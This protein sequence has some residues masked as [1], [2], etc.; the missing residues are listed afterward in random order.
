MSQILNVVGLT[1][2]T[3]VIDPGK[4]LGI[5]LGGA[6][7][8]TTTT[9]TFTQTTN[10]NIIIPDA[11]TT[12]VGTDV[13][14]TLTN[15][16]ITDPSDNVLARGLWYSNGSASINFYSSAAPAAG[17]A[18]VASSSTTAS[19]MPVTSVSG[20][21][22]AIVST[23]GE[24][25]TYPKLSAAIAAGAT[26]ICIR[27]GTY[28]ETSAI[29]L[30]AGCII[31]GERATN[32]II[33]FSGL[34]T[35]ALVANGNGGVIQ[36][37]GTVSITSGTNTVTGSSTSFTSLVPG[38]II[39]LAG[40]F[41]TISSITSNS[42]LT[43]TSIYRGRSISG[44]SYAAYAVMAGFQIENLTILNS[45]GTSTGLNFTGLNSISMKRCVVSGFPTGGISFNI[46]IRMLLE[47]VLTQNSSAGDGMVLS[48]VYNSA[49]SLSGSVNNSGNGITVSNNSFNI[50]LNNVAVNNNGTNGVNIIGNSNAITVAN[51]IIEFNNIDGCI[52]NNSTSNINFVACTIYQNNNGIN[53]G[54]TSSSVTSCLVTNNK[55]DGIIPGSNGLITGNTSAYN[56]GNGINMVTNANNTITGNTINNNA[57]DGITINGNT[58]S[59]TVT[60]NTIYLNNGRGIDIGSAAGGNNVISSNTVNNNAQEGIYIKSNSNVL[61]GNRC[62]GNSVGVSIQNS[63]DCTIVSGC[64]L[65]TNTTNYIN[66]G[67]NTLATGNLT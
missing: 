49:L 64:N 45:G 29:T 56:G 51:S 57:G 5:G 67:S 47:N 48:N 43:I 42:S 19:W 28:T 8:G 53:Y 11:S 31:V 52:S 40:A 2:I 12:L 20:M 22:S 24:P 10:R 9:F 25:G 27:A 15:K 30:P 60:G 50:L 41:Y 26:H 3:D 63:A 32:T 37:S 13:V 21:C 17:Y 33:V 16:T 55:G 46:I 4:V 58:Q 14:Q 36:T 6:T 66:N 61:T 38:N 39:L 65:R 59:N 18:L 23:G 34:S 35:P 44:T 62:N 7:S 54:G 1:Q